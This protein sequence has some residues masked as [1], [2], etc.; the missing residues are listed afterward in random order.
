MSFTSATLGLLGILANAEAPNPGR[1]NFAFRWP[2][3]LRCE[4]ERKTSTTLGSGPGASKIMR[5]ALEA[6]RDGAGWLIRRTYIDHR[7]AEGLVPRD[8]Q[9]MADRLPAYRVRTNGTFVGLVLEPAAR[10]RLRAARAK[11]KASLAAV[12]GVPTGGESPNS[13]AA[14]AKQAAGEWAGLV[15]AWAGRALR[16]AEPSSWQSDFEFALPFLGPR[17]MRRTETSLLVGLRPCDDAGQVSTSCA[18]LETVIEPDLA[19]FNRSMKASAAR[20]K[21]RPADDAFVPESIS[22]VRGTITK[23]LVTDPQTLIPRSLTTVMDHAMESAGETS[24][25]RMEQ[26]DTFRC[27][28]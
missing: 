10:A 2:D 7:D 23:R 16:P 13:E 9:L 21:K 19:R 8:P 20:R 6:R 12:G 26:V 3:G 17:R 11:W 15:E 27:T 24:S 22:F 25:S 14:L 5:F 1:I 4:V 18:E 28:P